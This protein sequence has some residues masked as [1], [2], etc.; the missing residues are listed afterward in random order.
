M[1]AKL[2]FGLIV[3][4]IVLCAV[5]TAT[6]LYLRDKQRYEYKKEMEEM[7]RKDRIWDKYR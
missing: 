5:V 1:A 3:L 7:E 2:V 4:T 6:Y